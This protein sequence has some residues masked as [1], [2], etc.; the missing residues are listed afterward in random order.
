MVSI[1]S[2][3][4]AESPPS[5]GQHAKG[6]PARVSGQKKTLADR[7][8][9][10]SL[11]VGIAHLCFKVAGF[12]LAIAVGRYFDDTTFDVIYVF[13]FEGILWGMFFRM[14]E[15]TIGP[16][17]LPVFK[18][19][20]DLRDE[21]SAWRF[22]NVV[23]TVQTVL[24][25]VAVLLIMLFPAEVISLGTYWRKQVDQDKFAL[26]RESLVWI[27]PALLCLSLGST[28]YMILNGY[29]KFFLAA[30][31]DAS[32]KI[33]VLIAV[34][35]G[36][37]MYGMS[38]RALFFGLLV[39]SVAKLATHLAGLLPKLRFL[40]PSFDLRH[41]AFKALLI[42][43]LPMIIGTF[44]SIVR[45]YFNNVYVLSYIDTPGLM[46]ANSFGRKLFL[47]I[48]WLVPYTV[49]IAMFPFFCELV[50]RDDRE[51][52][53]ELMTGSGRMILSLLIPGALLIAVLSEPLA[54]LLFRGGEFTERTALWAALSNAC[55]ILV[56]PAYS[57]EYI[58]M[59]GYFANRKMTLVIII[60]IVFSMF[61]VGV[62]YVLIVMLGMRD[63]QALMAVALGYTISR[64]LKVTAL[65]VMLKRTVPMFR[66]GETL[67]FLLR[68][69]VLALATAAVGYAVMA[70]FESAVSADAGKKILMAKLM[71]AGS[72]GAVVFWAGAYLLRL[73][74]PFDMIRWGLAKVKGRQEPTT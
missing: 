72:G 8:V 55:Y 14:G 46:K 33:C 53:G 16:C 37:G 7:I 12:V 24:L 47:A 62:S 40:R 32:W 45:D 11:A 20:V 65:V 39:G 36:I 13:A 63:T 29:K 70:G 67:V 17:F 15:E 56:L 25:V 61:S 51:R 59:Q 52:L 26:A 54:L 4:A 38:Y 44:F 35:V 9:G 48:A 49:A 27:A 60:G 64:T 19:E 5:F 30:F 74:E 41:P 57:L 22:T 31:G 28:T 58:L 73:R 18:E 2:G 71:L 69:G 6:A 66:T 50:D 23:L 42:L 10:A 1:P 34:V 43:M 68:C 3:C 21:R